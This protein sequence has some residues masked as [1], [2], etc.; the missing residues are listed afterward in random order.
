MFANFTLIS[1]YI[2]QVI[3]HESCSRFSDAKD[4]VVLCGS[5]DEPI[6]LMHI[7]TLYMEFI[8]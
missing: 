2:I 1:E 7:K 5:K 6:F 8:V 4:I 3:E